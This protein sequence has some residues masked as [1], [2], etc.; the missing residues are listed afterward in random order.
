[1]HAAHNHR[2]LQYIG[3]FVTSTAN[4]SS[5]SRL[6]SATSNR[7]EVP[8]TRLKFGESAF[9]VTGPTAWN[10]LP[11]EITDNS[12]INTLQSKLK[13]CLFTMAFAKI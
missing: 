2:W 6:R 8:E 1:M 4:I 9:S 5:R 13:T 11:E 7:Y 3:R 10:N 12:E